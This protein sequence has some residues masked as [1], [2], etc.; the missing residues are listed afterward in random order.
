[1]KKK[2][3]TVKANE[4]SLTKKTKVVFVD[5]DKKKAK[6]ASKKFI[7]KYSKALKILADR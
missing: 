6:A 4:P 1:M 3:Y 5:P 2:V 7:A